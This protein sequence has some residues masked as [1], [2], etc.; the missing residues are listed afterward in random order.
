MIGA[1]PCT[2]ARFDLVCA[3]D[4]LE[5]VQATMARSPNWHV[6]QKL[7]PPC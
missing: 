1:L 7:A 5:H 4:I 3:L 6:S 2:A